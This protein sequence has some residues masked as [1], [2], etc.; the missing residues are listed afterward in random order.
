MLGLFVMNSSF[1]VILNPEVA[2]FTEHLSKLPEADLKY[3]IFMCDYNDSPFWQLPDEVRDR[4]A[5][6]KAYENGEKPLPRP[7]I[8]AAMEEY[9]T[10]VWDEEQEQRRMLTNKIH[11]LNKALTAEES[12]SKIKGILNSISLLKEQKANLDKQLQA[13][14]DS[15]VIKGKR[16]LSNMELWQRNQKRRKEYE[17]I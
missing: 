8:E 13:Q 2:A 10:L 16:E 11:R 15:I 7:L 6:A 12:D 4:K 5:M 1:K 17:Q 9:R 3:V 14:A